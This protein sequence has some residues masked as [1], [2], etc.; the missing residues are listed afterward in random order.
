MFRTA[1]AVLTLGIG[2]LAALYYF[3]SFGRRTQMEAVVITCINTVRTPEWLP[4]PIINILNRAYDLIPASHGLVVE[5]GEIGHNESPL[6]AGVP[7]SKSAVRVLYNKSYINLFD[8]RRGQ[9]RCVAFKLSSSD[10]EQADIPADFFEDPRIRELRAADIRMSQWDAQ[11]LAP[12]QAL[13]GEFSEIGANEAS[14]VTNLVP[15]RAAFHAGLWQ[16]LLREITETYA[17]RFDE[18]WIYLG[19]IPGNNGSQS[20]SGVPIPEWFYAI[21]FDVTATGGLRAIAFLIPEHAKDTHLRDYITSIERIEA[22]S[23]L[24]FLPEIEYDARDALRLTVS[25]QLW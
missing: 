8:E 25:P 23:G 15:M 19:P 22:L 14:L 11:P 3:G 6:I 12:P 1:L 18:I 13:A 20:S 4:Q 5:G 24:Q 21:A 10:R 17:Q 7:L 2:T 9:T 16:R